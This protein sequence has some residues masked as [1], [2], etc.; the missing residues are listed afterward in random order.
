VECTATD[1]SGNEATRTFTVS[2]VDT[3]PPLLGIPSDITTPATTS[4]GASLQF[5]VAASDLV[6]PNVEIVCAPAAGSTFPINSANEW[7]GVV[8]EAIDDAGNGAAATFRVHV[9]G[10]SEQMAD[11]ITLFDGYDLEKLGTSLR[12]KLTTAQRQLA[13]GK[14]AQAEDTL[15]AFVTQVDAQRG[16]ALSSAQADE[17][18]AIATRII[19]VIE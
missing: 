9:Q 15:G 17:L 16:N 10:A 8:C 3:T 12:D 1:R 6:D 19:D 7:T 4:A 2:V 11:L 5:E 13:S 14:N 18:L